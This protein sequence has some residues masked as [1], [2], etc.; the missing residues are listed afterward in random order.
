MKICIVT[1]NVV[2][3]DGQGKVNC[4]VIQEALHRSHQVTVLSK[5]IEDDL[6]KH[7]LLTWIPVSVEKYPTQLVKEFVFSLRCHHWLSQNQSSFDLLQ[8]DGAS[9]VPRPH[10]FNVVHFVHTSWLESPIHTS[11]TRTGLYAVY[12]WLYT[13][14][15]SIWEKKLFSS[16]KSIIAVSYCIRDQLVEVGVPSSKIQVIHNGVDTQEFLPGT[17]RR[18]LLDLPADV[19]LGL[20]VGDIKTN[21]KNLDSVLYSL[22]NLPKV[23]LAVVGNKDGSPYPELAESL[24]MRER[25]HFMGHRKDMP[26]IMRSADFFVFP[27]RYE[28][29]GMVISE[30]MASGIPVVISKNSGAAEIVDSTC[31]FIIDAEDTDSLTKSIEV[32]S[33]DL[34]LRQTMGESGRRIAEHHTWSSKATSYINLFEE[35]CV[36]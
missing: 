13:K 10:D 7:P 29:F 9:T 32:L 14:L 2:R 24:G 31:G 11:K 30:A 18:D 21:R 12:Q 23:H 19:P 4:E 6:L 27:S 3:H 17:S 8:I 22:K 5:T 33:K 28:P 15:N 26:Q 35:A 16:A 20:F 36:G 1:P 34:A 25:V